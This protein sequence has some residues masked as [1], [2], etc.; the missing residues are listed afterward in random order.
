MSS[1]NVRTPSLLFQARVDGRTVLNCPA[2]REPAQIRVIVNDG[3]VPL[4]GIAG[5]GADKLGLCALSAFVEGQKR[6]IRETDWVWGC[7]GNWTVPAGDEWE[8]MAGYPPVPPQ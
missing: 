6:M 8:T 1:S 2:R 5:C 7:H 4:T 3:A